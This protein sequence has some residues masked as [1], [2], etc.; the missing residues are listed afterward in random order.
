[1]LTQSPLVCSSHSIVSTCPLHVSILFGA[2]GGHRALGRG[3]H[4]PRGEGGTHC[5]YMTVSALTR[6]MHALTR[7][8][9]DI[10]M[11]ELTYGW[12]AATSTAVVV[13]VPDAFHTSGR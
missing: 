9:K 8:Y 5:P 13:S 1:M 12:T 2:V 10:V 4:R 11:P 7:Q 3:G 6:T